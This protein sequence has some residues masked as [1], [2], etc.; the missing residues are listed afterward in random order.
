MRCSRAVTATTLS[1]HARRSGHG[2]RL[3]LLHRLMHRLRNAL[4]HTLLQALLRALPKRR[5]EHVVE[6]ANEA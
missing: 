4:G 3:L 1:V 5:I 2:R 6:V